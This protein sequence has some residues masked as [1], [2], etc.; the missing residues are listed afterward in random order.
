MTVS[1]DSVRAGLVDELCLDLVGPDNNHP[2]ANELLSQ[3]PSRW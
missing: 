3:S 2:F 1:S